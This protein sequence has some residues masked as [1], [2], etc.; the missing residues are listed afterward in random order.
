MRKAFLSLLLLLSI[1]CLSQNKQIL[2][3]FTA[4]PQSL[5]TN[6][7][8]EFKY[9]Y[10]FGVP[11]L[12]GISVNVGSTGFSAYEL[13]AKDGVD[14]NAK[15]RAVVMSTSRKDKVTLNEQIELFNGGFKVGGWQKPA[16]VSFGMYQEFDFLMYIP[17]DLAILALEGNRDYLGKKF[18]LADLNL[19]TEMLS[20]LH[21]GYHRNIAENLNVGARVKIYS[22]IFN[23]TSTNNKGYVLTEDGTTT[24]YEQVMDSNMQLNTSGVSHYRDKNIDVDPASDLIKKTFAG[25][26]L[27]LGFDLGFTYYPKKNI[28][29]TASV[30]D[31]G[32]I[33]HS[34][35][36]ESWTY[37]GLYKYEGV[38]PIFNDSNE[39]GN[40]YQEFNDAIPL[41]SIYTNY[42]TWRPQKFNASYQYSFNDSRGGDCSCASPDADYKNAVGAQLFAMTAPRGPI[43]ALTGYYRRSVLRNLEMKATYTLDSYSYTN[44]GLGLSTNVGKFNLYALAD[45]LLEYRDLSKTNSLSF[46]FG[47]NFIFKDNN[48]P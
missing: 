18:N 48:E 31:V 33:K 46:Q 34:K 5:L 20:V 4:V 17:K 1:S 10:Y 24:S 21:F 2:Y 44:I 16:Y 25:G 45:N 27:G 6:P 8:A 15:L 22:S 26:N 42:T 30:L 9:K 40:V 28:Q 47:F 7:G 19:K 39:P 37:K 12:S 29:I 36:V 3:N 13:F 11:L 32:Y 23:A 35:Q 43:V 38:N 14:F 41:D